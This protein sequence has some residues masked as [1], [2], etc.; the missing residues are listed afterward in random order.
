MWPQPYK[1]LS[2]AAAE[3]RRLIKSPVLLASSVVHPRHSVPAEHLDLLSQADQNQPV[4]IPSVL[5]CF[6]RWWV[7]VFSAV[8]DSLWLAIMSFTFHR[9]LGPHTSVDILVKSWVPGR[10][11]LSKPDDFYYGPLQNLLHKQGVRTIFL[12]G[13]A[14]SDDGKLTSKLKAGLESWRF[15]RDCLKIHQGHR[16]PDILLV[17][18]T[19]PLRALPSQLLCAIR[20]RRLARQESRLWIKRIAARAAL[21]VLRPFTTKNYMY[22][23]MG[24]RAVR[25]WTPKAVI[26][27]FEGQ[28]WEKVFWSAVK[29][30]NPSLKLAGYQHTVVLPH[31]L[32]L[33][34]PKKVEGEVDVPDMVLCTGERTLEI[35]ESGLKNWSPTFL[36]Y[37]SHR[38]IAT[39][40]V[41][42]RPRP[43]KK[44]VLILPEGILS[45]MILLFDLAM[46]M[47]VRLPDHAFVFRCHPVL[48]YE[49]VEPHLKKRREDFQNIEL[50]RVPNIQ[51]DFSRASTLIY[52]GSSA[53]LY[54]V[55]A[56]VKPLYWNGEPGPVVDPLCWVQGWKEKVSSLEE[57]LEVLKKYSCESSTDETMLVAWEKAAQDVEGLVQPLNE[58]SVAKLT[59][60]LLYNRPPI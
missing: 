26:S 17:P 47:A 55:L 22:D 2:E 6:V 50:S 13:D 58:A 5:N 27:L 45:E 34:N 40:L 4:K 42:I 56:G 44:T 21:D 60:Y 8:Y 25:R 52:R 32:A 33:L 7:C 36:A 59:Q 57:G 39:S 3:I 43:E 10:E 9:F 30:V 11:G 48:P 23:W 41:D 54:S 31:S 46:E 29:K 28:P 19:A 15:V 51:D 53:A 18:W 49:K 35:L 37:G 16:F 14:K 20:L 1:E 38:R 24:T 12:V